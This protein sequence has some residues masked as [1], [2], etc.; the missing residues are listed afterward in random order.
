MVARDT[1]PQDQVADLMERTFGVGVLATLAA[2]LV[3]GA[4]VSRRLRRRMDEIGRTSR[5]IMAGDLSRRIP[6]GVDDR[7]FDGLA[8]GLNE[9]LARIEE[10]M[11]GVREVTD[12]I[13]HDMRTPLTRLRQHLEKVRAAGL[14]LDEFRNAVDIALLETDGLLETFG[15]LLRIAQIEARMPGAG[16]T[17]IDLSALCASMADTYGPV[18]EA[19]ETE[20]VAAIV[21]GLSVAGDRQL[22]MQ[23]LVNLI[24]NALQHNRPGTEIRLL[25]WTEGRSAALA[26]TDDGVGIPAG[27]RE[28][29]LRRFY[30]LDAARSSQGSGLGLSLVAAIAKYHGATLELEDNGPGLK[31]QMRLPLA[32]I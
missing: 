25:L 9:M 12:N 19:E 24:E 14:T 29:V 15:A 32:R 18:A 11:D 27:E 28:N 2:A 3:T 26:V 16:L 13:A 1:Y 4:I 23:L 8:V 7:D 10:L 31:V 5:E 20:L 17:P 21:P 30:R 22:L 6:V